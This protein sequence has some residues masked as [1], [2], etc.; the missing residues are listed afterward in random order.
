MRMSSRSPPTDVTWYKD[1]LII[2]GTRKEE[3]KLTP[4][5][6]KDHGVTSVWPRAIPMRC[7]KMKPSLK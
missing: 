3:K 4:T 1:N 2:G 5:L 7:F 6:E